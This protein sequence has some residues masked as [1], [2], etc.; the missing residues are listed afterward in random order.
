[1]ARFGSLRCTGT[2][3]AT[4]AVFM[5]GPAAAPL[6]PAPAAVPKAHPAP[7]LAFSRYIDRTEGAFLALVPRGWK[8]QGGIV[9]INALAAQGG[10]GN[11]AEAK[12]DFAV[13]REPD[14]R[15]GIRWLPKINYAQPS[16]GNAMLGGNWNG[17][18]VLAMPKAADYLSRLLFPRLRAGAR[19]H[20][21]RSS[22]LTS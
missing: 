17:M 1:M 19:D 4:L 14:G 22:Q 2:R 9:R 18:P 21:P 3:L 13:L 6:H 5:A 11:A 12:L 10:V 20:P 8:V 7:R 16:P 15:V